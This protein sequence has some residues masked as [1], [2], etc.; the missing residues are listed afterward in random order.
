MKNEIAS[1]KALIDAMNKYDN[2]YTG[3]NF[4][5]QPTDLRIP[6]ELPERLSPKATTRYKR[7]VC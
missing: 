4:D 2:I 3:M 7:N 1:D 6:I 5:N